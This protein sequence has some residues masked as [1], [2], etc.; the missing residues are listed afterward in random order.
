MNVLSKIK[1]TQKMNDLKRVSWDEYFMSLCLCVAQRSHDIHSKYG[2][3]IVDDKYRVLSIGYNGF[4]RNTPHEGMSL[5]RPDKY[6]YMVHAEENAIINATQCLDKATLYIAGY[7]CHKC[8]RMIIQA[9]ITKVIYGPITAKCHDADDDYASG[10]ML[11][12][13]SIEFVDM[14]RSASAVHKF[15]KDTSKYLKTKEV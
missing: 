14:S 13:Q 15:L 3:I 10:Q 9:G 5:E 7:P 4:P 12:G 2:A 6:F 1:G 8:M 11:I